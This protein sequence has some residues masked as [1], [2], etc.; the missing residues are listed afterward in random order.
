MEDHLKDEL[1][2]DIKILL[3]I[4]PATRL[5]QSLDC[6]F[7][8]YLLNLKQDAIPMNFEDVVSDM[9]YLQNYLEKLEKKVK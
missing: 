1:F 8:D 6:V 7:K 2:N 9:Y 4:A 5:L 3:E